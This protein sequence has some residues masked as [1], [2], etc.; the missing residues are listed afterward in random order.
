MKSVCI[1]ISKKKKIF[2][3][4]QDENQLGKQIRKMSVMS[5]KSIAN[6]VEVINLIVE[7]SVFFLWKQ[8]AF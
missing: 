6:L 5:N 1:K 2:F 7:Y 8:S 3:F 4:L